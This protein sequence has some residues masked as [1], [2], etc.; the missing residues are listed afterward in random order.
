M[1]KVNNLE[2]IN[3]VNSVLE[4]DLESF[5]AIVDKYGQAV[6]GFVYKLIK[7]IHLSED[8]TQEVFITVYN[9]LHLYN[10]RYKFS[11]WI[12]QI[13][14][15]KTIDYM[16]KQKNIKE[17]SIEKIQDI[18]DNMMLPEEFVEYKETYEGLIEYINSLEEEERKI[19]FF[20]Y[21]EKQTFSYISKILK[22]P[23]ST[24]KK[25]FYKIREKYKNMKRS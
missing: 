5:D 21:K 25:R 18:K 17:Q 16:R 23:E 4:G 11:S 12:L 6:Y 2:D 10:S 15:N 19:I 24:V 9:K 20:K 7:D 22:I 3:L 1:D 14:K 13:A 8:I